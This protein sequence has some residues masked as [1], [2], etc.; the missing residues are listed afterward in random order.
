M[1]YDST[2]LPQELGGDSLSL[3]HDTGLHSLDTDE[4][5]LVNP[6]FIG[7][8]LSP[9]RPLARMSRLERGKVNTGREKCCALYFRQLKVLF[10][11]ATCF[12]ILVFRMKKP[13]CILS[14]VRIFISLLCLEGYKNGFPLIYHRNLNCVSEHHVKSSLNSGIATHKC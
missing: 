11:K 8:P 3:R 14:C 9:V 7:A 4:E 1:N 5:V 12:S 10:V 13:L 6:F 2:V